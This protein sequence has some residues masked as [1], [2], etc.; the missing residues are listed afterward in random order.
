MK[1]KPKEH[2]LYLSDRPSLTVTVEPAPP[3]CSTWI[4]ME[5]GEDCEAATIRA[6]YRG[7]GTIEIGQET[8]LGNGTRR[9]WGTREG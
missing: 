5:T 9:H 3:E 7:R 2:H 8:G 4:D 1:R 6:S